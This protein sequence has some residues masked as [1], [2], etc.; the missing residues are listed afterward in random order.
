MYRSEFI[1]RIGGAVIA[2]FI[3]TSDLGPT[4]PKRKYINSRIGLITQGDPMDYRV[5]IHAYDMTL[6]TVMDQYI[7]YDPDF[8]KTASVGSVPWYS[9]ELI[10]SG[11]P[12]DYDKYDISVWK[13]WSFW[14]SRTSYAYPTS[15]QKK[16]WSQLYSYEIPPELIITLTDSNV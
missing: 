12:G 15:K 11:M 10:V 5:V 16:V 7:P 2:P 8:Q 1:K 9:R 13:H 6:E 14:P 4:S 3:P